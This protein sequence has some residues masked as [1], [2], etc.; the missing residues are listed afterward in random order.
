MPS[1]LT[2]IAL[3]YVASVT[4]AYRESMSYELTEGIKTAL[5]AH[6]DLLLATTFG[7][8]TVHYQTTM[9]VRDNY[10]LFDMQIKRVGASGGYSALQLKINRVHPYAAYTLYASRGGSY[11]SVSSSTLESLTIN[12]IDRYRQEIL[13]A[14]FNDPVIAAD[15]QVSILDRRG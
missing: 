13:R 3:S 1:N 11:R 9:T 6:V 14:L 4:N 2:Q 7:T 5:R 10:I 8:G 15:D 12:I